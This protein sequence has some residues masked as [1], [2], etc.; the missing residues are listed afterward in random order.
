[1]TFQQLMEQVFFDLPFVFVYLDDMLVASRSADEH[2]VHLR[3]VLQLLSDNGL[4]INA[5]K[6]IWGQ[7]QLEFLGHQV[8]TAG[9]TPLAA[10]V[11][12]IQQFQRPCNV[13]QLQ[14]FLGLL[15]FYRKFIPAAAVVRPLTDA[16]ADTLSRPVVADTLSRPPTATTCSF[17][18]AVRG[19]GAGLQPATAAPPSSSPPSPS[20]PSWVSASTLPA[21][22]PPGEA[23]QAPPLDIH[24]IA[25]AQPDCQDCQR[26]RSSPALRV[27]SVQME[28]AT[29][30]VDVSSGV[31]RLLVPAHL[32]RAVFSA[33]HSLAHPALGPL[34]ASSPADFCGLV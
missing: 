28:G 29:V 11:T 8:S 25:A 27:I 6:C 17:A 14:G 7:Q 9:I 12:A 16:V 1:M 21:P 13:Q 26:A 23:S 15:N 10:R 33:V 24:E 18:D 22:V 31:M 34:G 4:V 30:L 20:A 2:K 19:Q 32:R 5:D 3:Q